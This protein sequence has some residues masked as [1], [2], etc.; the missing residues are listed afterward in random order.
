[1]PKLGILVSTFD[2]AADLWGPLHEAY[3]RYWPDNPYRVYLSTNQLDPALGGMVALKVGQEQ[4]WS[5]NIFKSLSLLDEEY[6]LLTFDD[7]F[8]MARVDTRSI[9]NYFQTLHVND[10]SYL[11]LH[12][13]PKPTERIDSRFGRV[14][15]GALYRASTVWSMWKK[16][17]LIAL[18][19]R[20]ESAWQFE[21]NGSVRSAGDPYYY[22][23]YQEVIPYKNAVI[24]G[25]WVPVVRGELVARGFRIDESA[26]R[27]MTR[28][29]LWGE[30]ARQLRGVL[31]RWLVPRLWQHRVKSAFSRNE[32]VQQ[33]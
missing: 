25:L 33:K 3:A 4:S 24:K 23:T 6:V 12:P 2:G 17:T 27:Q 9:A 31:F 29:E 8:P 26:R 5:D 15:E 18:L 14:K 7:L 22:R 19:D 21:R 28:T 1:M 30:R 16:E 13:S 11:G 10:M 32:Y 20:T